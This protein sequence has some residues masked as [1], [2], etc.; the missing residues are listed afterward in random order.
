VIAVLRRDEHLRERVSD[1]RLRMGDTLLVACDETQLDALRNTD[2]F[3]L[4]EGVAHEVLRRDKA[5]IA[6]A[7]MAGM[8]VL[9]SLGVAPIATLALTAVALMVLTGCLP[10]RLAYSWI[11]STIVVLIAGM[12]A[13]GTALEKTGIASEVA[14]SLVEVLRQHGPTAVLAGIY[15]LAMVVT[16]VVSNNAV[17]VLMTPIAVDAA[18]VMGLNPTP[19]VFATLFGASAC[20]ATPIGYQTNL[21]VYGPGGYRF[22]DYLRVGTPLNAV[23]FVAAMIVIPWWFPLTPSG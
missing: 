23:L 15:V 21:F 5:P 18:A 2:E 22:S 7:V 14:G 9:A 13:L 11:D 10:L 1:V 3:I 20:F 17:A 8:V 19:F 4:L 6:A 12:L 16:S